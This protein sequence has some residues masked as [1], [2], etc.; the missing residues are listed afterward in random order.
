MKGAEY[1]K[2]SSR[3]IVATL[4]LKK[5]LQYLVQQKKL[6]EQEEEERRRKELEEEEEENEE[7]KEQRQ[8][9][10]Y[11]ID[12]LLNLDDNNLPQRNNDEEQSDCKQQLFPMHSSCL[13]RLSLVIHSFNHSIYILIS[14]LMISPFILKGL[15]DLLQ[16]KID[17]ITNITTN[18]KKYFIVIGN[19]KIFLLDNEFEKLQAQINFNSIDRI[20]ISINDPNLFQMHM[21]E[22]KASNPSSLIPPR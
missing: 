16:S 17:F 3:D 14:I 10:N 9:M 8:Q 2:F 1:S 15:G 18:A 11:E 5:R 4:V 13:I 19:G 21:N 7:K 6:R 12:A 22:N 20:I